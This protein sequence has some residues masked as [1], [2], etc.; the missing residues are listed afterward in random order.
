MS[1]VFSQSQM[2]AAALVTRLSKLAVLMVGPVPLATSS[3]RRS[4]LKPAMVTSSS[5]GS[6]TAWAVPE[7]MVGGEAASYSSSHA[8]SAKLLPK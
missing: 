7:T 6:D 4:M 5:V 8:L 1:G 2:T 3:N